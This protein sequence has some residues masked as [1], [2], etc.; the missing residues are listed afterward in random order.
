MSVFLESR[1]AACRVGK[2]GVERLGE[3]RVH[4]LSREGAGDVADSGVRGKGATAEL[5]GGNDDFAAIGL[6][7]SNGG[8]VELRERDLGDAAGKKSDAGTALALGREG[9]PEAG[10]EKV[11]VDAREE[12]GALVQSEQAENA[13]DARGR[14]EAGALR[15]AN[16]ASEASEAARIRKQLAVNEIANQAR[17]ARTFIV[18]SD[19]GARELDQFAVFDAGGAG[20]FASSAIEAAVDVRDETFAE[21]ETALID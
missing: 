9:L 12:R 15:E 11:G 19:L 13:G 5:I 6:K 3:E 16:E 8:V 17:A 14:F 1:A 10:K 2:D 18:A 20:G 7:H 4:V 21:S